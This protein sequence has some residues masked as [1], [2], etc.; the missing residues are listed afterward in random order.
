MSEI[1]VR[2]L[3]IHASEIVRKVKES[4]VR[5]VITRRGRP[6]AMLVPLEEPPVAPGPGQ[7]ETD[8]WQE[9]VRLGKEISQRWESPLSSTELLSEMRR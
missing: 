7:A 8:A 6:A 9:L 4:G 1:S 2:E 3:K 5:Y